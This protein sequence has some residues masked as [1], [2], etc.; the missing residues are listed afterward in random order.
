MIVRTHRSSPKGLMQ[1]ITP[2]PRS[3]VQMTAI[4]TWS[5]MFGSPTR[6]VPVE[7]PP[8]KHVGAPELWMTLFLSSMTEPLAQLLATPVLL[9]TMTAVLLQ[10][11][12]PLFRCRSLPELPT[13]Y[14]SVAGMVQPER[15][16]WSSM[17][18][19]PTTI[20][21]LLRLSSV[22]EHSHS[23]TLFRWQTDP[24]TAIP[25]WVQMVGSPTLQQ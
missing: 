2:L 23:I 1:L 3:M 17:W 4:P 14:R 16:I 13:L 8:L 12:T 6:R 24:M 20:A 18:Q 19:W 10:T 9:Q 7:T 15:P 25:T 11:S 21:R 22:V 5:E